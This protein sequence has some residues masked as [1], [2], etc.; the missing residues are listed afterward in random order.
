MDLCSLSLELRKF[1]KDHHNWA[2][3]NLFFQC[4]LLF[5]PIHVYEHYVGYGKHQDGDGDGVGDDN[6]HEHNHHNT[7][8][9][10]VRN[11]L[12]EEAIQ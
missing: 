4:R 7:V 8:H 11:L 9:S 12:Y 3:N 2:I 5:H 1:L 10:H 6:L